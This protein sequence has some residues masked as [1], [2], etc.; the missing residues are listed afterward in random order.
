MVVCA[1]SARITKSFVGENLMLLKR[2]LKRFF[3]LMES[4]KKA[5]VSLN[6]LDEKHTNLMKIF[7]CFEI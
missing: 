6:R 1:A 2:Q 7:I 5:K 3:L 4:L